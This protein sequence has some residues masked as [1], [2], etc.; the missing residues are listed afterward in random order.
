MNK[1]YGMTNFEIDFTYKFALALCGFDSAIDTIIS[2]L[3]SALRY[4]YGILLTGWTYHE[5]YNQ[6]LKTNYFQKV[7]EFISWE[8]KYGMIENNI[9][10]YE[11]VIDNDVVMGFKINKVTTECTYH[12]KNIYI[13]NNRTPAESLGCISKIRQ[14][15]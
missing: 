8:E 9:F 14:F 6:S 10:I 3:H 7:D 1:V 13:N 12:G 11:I 15:I 5:K 2:N 4:E